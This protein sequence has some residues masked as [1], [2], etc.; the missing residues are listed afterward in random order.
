MPKPKKR[1][2]HNSKHVHR[3]VLFPITVLLIAAGLI[4]WNFYGRNPYPETE[5]KFGMTFSTKYSTELGLDW[6]EVYTASLDDLGIRYFRIPVYWDEVEYKYGEYNLEHVQW[7]MDE[8]HKRGALVTL[9]IGNRVPRWPECHPPMWTIN[10]S[11][12]EVQAGEIKMITKVVQEFKDH[13]ALYRWQVHNEPFFEQ[14]GECPP[15]DEEFIRESIA[16]V[17]SLDPDHPIQT[18]D[19]GELS[20]WEKTAD[21]SD[22]LGISMYRVTWNSIFKYFYYPLP[23]A[24]YTKKAEFI[25]PL[26]DEV[27]ISELQ[28]EPWVPTTM[29][30]TPLDEQYKSMNEDRFWRNIDY[31]RRTGFSET[32]LWG[33]EW[34]YWLREVHDDSGMW[35]AGKQ[36]Y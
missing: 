14:F 33:V 5:T 2:Y 27:I 23:P 26:V 6:K 34:W 35:E 21:V 29:T 24:H 11:K 20:T 1:K 22:V 10:K 17:R 12:V 18:T 9:A 8:A 7:M 13:P 15:P 36:L 25:A 28:A 31:A 3:Y 32:Y 19:S 16:H 30:T 4:F